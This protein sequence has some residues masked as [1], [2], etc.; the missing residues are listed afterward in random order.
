[1]FGKILKSLKFR[2]TKILRQLF[3][4]EISDIQYITNQLNIDVTTIYDIGANVGNTVKVFNKLFSNSTIHTFEPNPDVFAKLKKNCKAIPNTYFNNVGVGNTSGILKLNRHINSGATSFK[5]PNN[6]TNPTY[7][8]KI[9]DQ[10][11]V[12]VITLNE[13]FET[14]KTTSIDLMKIDVEGFEMEVLNG[15]SDN[16]LKNHVKI[17]MIEANLIEKMIGQGLIED[18]I[19]HLRKNNFTLYNIYTQ[20]E[21]DK[22]QLNIVN[23]IFA[24]NSLLKI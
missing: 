23:L 12:P 18:I 24:N 8:E 7:K 19:E 3:K 5:D 4:N 22:R 1:M 13:Y 6:T 11:E 16:L 9:I 15:I 14:S 17:I 10:I 2:L 21:S 20:Q